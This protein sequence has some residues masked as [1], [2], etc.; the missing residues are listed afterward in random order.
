MAADSSKRPSD[1]ST[2]AGPTSRSSGTK[3]LARLKVDVQGLGF[4]V[5]ALVLGAVVSVAALSIA[6]VDILSLEIAP[7]SIHP[8]DLG[9]WKT[10]YSTEVPAIQLIVIAALGMIGVA[11]A[12]VTIEIGATILLTMDPKRHRLAAYRRVRSEKVEAIGPVDVT[13]IIPAHNEEVMLPTTLAS[14]KMQSRVPNRVI[15]VADNCTDRTAEVAVEA[16][17]EVFRTS[18][19]THKKAGALNQVLRWML[20]ELGPSNAVLIMDADT[21]L[22]DRFIEAAASRLDEDQELAAVGGVFTGEEGR[23]LI[24]LLQRNEYARYATQ[25]RARR[26]RVFVLT[27]TAT[28]FRAD[29]LLDVSAARGIYIPGEPGAVYD[30]AALTEDNELTLAL[31]SLGATM[32]SPEECVVVTEIMPTWKAL[33]QQRQRWQRGALENLSAYGITTGTV[34]YWGQ[35]FGIGY[36]VVALNSA[37][38]LMVITA[39]SVE[40]WVWFPFWMAITS[41]F[42]VE[43]VIGAWRNGWRGRLLAALLIPEILYDIYLQ[44]IF[45]KSLWDIARNRTAQWIYVE[46]TSKL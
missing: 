17:A 21:V 31:K 2:G 24:G 25:I 45:I 19:N 4:L 18:G 35:Q 26:G 38:A 8:V 46:R 33:W 1:Q 3:R 34:R 12:A 22:T 27:G 7:A 39:L 44:A 36:G 41:A 29:A 13:V 37:I 6:I 16:G 5:V 32:N 11:V 28:M 9:W 20:P 43:R 14:L 23:G 15:V 42:I 10:Y 40:A 30:T